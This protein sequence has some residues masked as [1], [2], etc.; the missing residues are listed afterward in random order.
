MEQKLHTNSQ[1]MWLIKLM[2]FDHVIEYKRGAENKVVDSLSRVFVADL[3]SL[4]IFT[5]SSELMQ[6]IANCWDTDLELKAL[7]E[8]LQADPAKE[9]HYWFMAF[10]TSK[11]P[12]WY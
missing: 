1:L 6:A 5:T 2:P 8:Q 7:I 4:I 9:R 11:W 3:F 10:H 12:F